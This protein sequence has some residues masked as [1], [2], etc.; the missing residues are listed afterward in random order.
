ME[1]VTGVEPASTAWEAAALPMCYT[2]MVR[3]EGLEPPALGLEVL[4]SIHL[5]YRRMEPV[6]GVEPIACRLGGG[7]SVH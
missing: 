7:R 1:R 2:R 5:S 4:C 3:L 6:M